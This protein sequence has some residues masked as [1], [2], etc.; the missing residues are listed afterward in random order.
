M[1]QNGLEQCTRGSSFGPRPKQSVNRTRSPECTD[2]NLQQ[3]PSTYRWCQ[4]VNGTMIL[5]G[6]ISGVSF[7]SRRVRSYLQLRSSEASELYIDITILTYWYWY[8]H[9]IYDDIDID[10]DQMHGQRAN[11]AD[12]QR[13][14]WQYRSVPIGRHGWWISLHCI[15]FCPTFQLPTTKYSETRNH[16]Y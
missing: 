7:L 3:V 14:R 16:H 13:N 11:E 6:V 4:D 15:R 2:V 9:M 1:P 8:W 12:S 5:C 10:T